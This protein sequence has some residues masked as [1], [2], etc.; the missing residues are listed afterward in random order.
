[1]VKNISKN[2]R[3]PVPKETVKAIMSDSFM[4]DSFPC[5]LRTRDIGV[6]KVN[7]PVVKDTSGIIRK[8]TGYITRLIVNN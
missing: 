5:V 1:M 2:T 7:L 8:I 6:K 4:D 3:K